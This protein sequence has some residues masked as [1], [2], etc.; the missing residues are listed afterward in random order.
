MDKIVLLNQKN[1]KTELSLELSLGLVIITN[2]DK[3]VL[4][5]QKNLKTE[6]SLGYH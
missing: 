6:L 4:L 2:M 3:I 5:N 1:L